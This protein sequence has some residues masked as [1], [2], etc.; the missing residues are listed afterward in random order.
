MT[1]VSGTLYFLADDGSGRKLWKTTGTTPTLVSSGN[2]AA[3]TAADGKLFFSATD[4]TNG[5]ELWVSDAMGTRR[6]KDIYPGLG[7]SN[8]S[9]LSPV[10]GAVYFTAFDEEHGVDV[11]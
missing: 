6:V 8:P 1:D 10:E 5:R 4:S 2:P 7:G 3:L 9:F 11:L